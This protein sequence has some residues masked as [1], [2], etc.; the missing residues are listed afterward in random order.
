VLVSESSERW[1]G[2]VVYLRRDAAQSQLLLACTNSRP[3]VSFSFPSSAFSTAAFPDFRIEESQLP[4]TTKH[5]FQTAF[6]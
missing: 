6:S 2:G 4:L 5:E 1:A 3:Q